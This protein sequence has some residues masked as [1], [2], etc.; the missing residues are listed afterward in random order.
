MKKQICFMLFVL[1]LPVFVFSQD[2]PINFTVQ[3]STDSILY[4]NYFEVK[5]TLENAGDAQF[6]APDFSEN[7]QVV[8]GPN[9]SSSISMMNGEVSQRISY[10]YYL[11]PKDIGT[12][13]ILPASVE[14][15]GEYAETQ[16]L[17]VFVVPNPDG[18]KQNVVP[19]QQ[20]DMF[21]GM[22]FFNF[23]M[24]SPFD[25]ENPFQYFNFE[26]P[27]IPVP[28]SEMPNDVPSEPLPKKKKLKTTRI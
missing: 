11:E 10:T 6:E 12:F 7:F 5:F 27:E 15:A 24:G 23:G 16:P 26:F 13:Y 18:I 1:A 25:G 19:G 14:A 21:N 8:S 2:K 20:M 22:D 17:E 4:G 3:V 9:T 28:P